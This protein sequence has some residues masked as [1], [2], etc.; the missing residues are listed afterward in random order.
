M[1]TISWPKN[2][3]TEGKKWLTM[4]VVLPPRNL[5]H[6]SIVPKTLRSISR[7]LQALLDLDAVVSFD[8]GAEGLSLVQGRVEGAMAAALD[9]VDVLANDFPV[10]GSEL[11]LADDLIGG[12]EAVEDESEEVKLVFV[13]LKEDPY[14]AIA[15]VMLQWRGHDGPGNAARLGGLGLTGG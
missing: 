8:N 6:A 11:V 13:R 10:I 14:C 1:H 15:L 9:V 7:V 12:G 3:M 4:L 2:T 5:S